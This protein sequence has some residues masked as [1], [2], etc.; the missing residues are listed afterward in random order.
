MVLVPQWPR[1]CS[2]G[3]SDWT[4]VLFICSFLICS[5]FYFFWLHFEWITIIS[6]LSLNSVNGFQVSNFVNISFSFRLFICRILR[7]KAKARLILTVFVCLLSV[8]RYV[9]VCACVRAHMCSFKCV[10]LCVWCDVKA[11]S[12]HHRQLRRLPRR[13]QLLWLATKSQ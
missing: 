6:H 5:I 1:M 7:S 3:F 2:W 11:S 8:C 9:C 10:C 12:P 13:L 4:F